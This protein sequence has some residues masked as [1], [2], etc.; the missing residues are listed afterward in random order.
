[1][2]FRKDRTTAAQTAANVA[3]GIVS[4]LVSAQ[5]ITAKDVEAKLVSVFD[6]IF[7]RLGPVVDADNLVFEAAEAA[8][9]AKSTTSSSSSS[10]S[11]PKGEKKFTLEEARDLV[12]ARGVFKDLTMGEVYDMD[13]AEA[14]THGHREGE[15]GA[16]Y[17]RWLST[18]ANKNGFT[19]AAAKAIVA[20][21][22]SAAA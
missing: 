20:S 4:A 1:M 9:P 5:D 3:G 18:E 21:E 8:A 16:T 11:K 13:A 17:V 2:A 6:A 15:A 22:D 10:S 12:L 19:R 14:G 7:E